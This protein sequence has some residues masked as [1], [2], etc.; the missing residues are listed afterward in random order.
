MMIIIYEYPK[1]S[2][3]KK[4]IKWLDDHNVSYEKRDIVKNPPSAQ[5]LEKLIED[6][7]LMLTKVFNTSGQKYRKLNL[8]D[9]VKQMT[10]QEACENYLS[11]DGMLIKRPVIINGDKVVFGFK[12]DKVRELCEG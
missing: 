5:L 6:N 2:T 1:C 4:A 12:E 11:Q 10:V 7:N 3:C 9:K 8:K